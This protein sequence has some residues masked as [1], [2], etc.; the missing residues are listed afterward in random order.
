LNLYCHFIGENKV[1][2]VLTDASHS[3]VSAKDKEPKEDGESN[4]MKEDVEDL[5]DDRE[6]SHTPSDALNVYLLI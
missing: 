1:G 4:D 2:S 6:V 3:S 5:D